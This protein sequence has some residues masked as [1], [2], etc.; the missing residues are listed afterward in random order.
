MSL[1]SHYAAFQAEQRGAGAALPDGPWEVVAGAEWVLG[2]AAPG[3]GG[4]PDALKPGL[5]RKEASKWLT[6]R[7]L[8]DLVED[9]RL[10]LSELVT[11]ALHYGVGAVSVRLFVI[12]NAEAGWLHIEVWDGS[13]DMPRVREAGLLDEGG[14]GLWLVRGLVEERR[15]TYGVSGDG[16]RTWCRTP[17]QMAA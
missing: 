5:V 16:R 17:V 9:I 14:R 11:N 8:A 2:R 4:A 10:V 13:S 6:K 1:S 7:G 3:A 15:G 12:K